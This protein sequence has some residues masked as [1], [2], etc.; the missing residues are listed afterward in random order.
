MVGPRLE[1][2][3]IFAVAHLFHRTYTPVPK[4]IQDGS[5]NILPAATVS[6][7]PM[8]LQGRTVRLVKAPNEGVKT[9]S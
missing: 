4:H 1:N 8:E 6:G 3:F 7:A 9:V 5:E 2:L